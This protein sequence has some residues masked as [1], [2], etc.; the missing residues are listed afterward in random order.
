MAKII[1]VD[2]DPVIA[3]LLAMKF[4]SEGHQAVSV[5]D[6]YSVAAAA[7]MNFKPD[8]ITLDFDL[9]TG[10]GFTVLAQ[11]RGDAVTAK[12]PVIFISGRAPHDLQAAAP[13]DPNIRF[14]PKPVDFAK[15]NVCVAELLSSKPAAPPRA[16]A[17]P[18]PVQSQRAESSGHALGR[19]IL[20]LDI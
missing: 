9:P 19:D 15:L 11:L 1:V 4:Q 3:E 10:D 2:D 5:L 17:R 16:A 8:L 18:L 12:T 6:F 7:A 13:D 14:L 20:D